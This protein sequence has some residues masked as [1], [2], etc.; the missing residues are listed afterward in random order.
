MSSLDFKLHIDAFGNYE[1]RN[2]KDIHLE[3]G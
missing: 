2:A 3:A 1:L